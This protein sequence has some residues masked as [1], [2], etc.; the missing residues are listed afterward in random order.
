MKQHDVWLQRLHTPADSPIPA[1]WAFCKK[2]GPDNKVSEFKTYDKK[3]NQSKFTEFCKT[4][5][6]FRALISSLNYLGVLTR[7]DIAYAVSSLS[8]YLENP[9]IL[10]YH[11]AVQDYR[12][13]SGTKTLVLTY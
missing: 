12:Y 5:I 2:L 11:A 9:G 10:H 8:Q 7:P 3:A 6:N 1:T 13:L 4:G